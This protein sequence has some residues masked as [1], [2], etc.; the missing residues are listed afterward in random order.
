MIKDSHGV[1]SHERRFVCCESR[2]MPRGWFDAKSSVSFWIS[3]W[4]I[5]SILFF[6]LFQFGLMNGIVA[7]VN[8]F[9]KRRWRGADL[10]PP[11]AVRNERRVSDWLIY[12]SWYP[13]ISALLFLF[14][15]SFFCFFCFSLQLAFRIRDGVIGD[16]LD[17]VETRLERPSKSRR[18]RLLFLIESTKSYWILLECHVPQPTTND[19]KIR[20]KIG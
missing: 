3:C 12:S 8:W 2:P 17:D 16:G 10:R 18:D 19:E 20:K 6:F 11:S 14:V 1:G 13:I 7:T 15:C 4:L 5:S 9:A